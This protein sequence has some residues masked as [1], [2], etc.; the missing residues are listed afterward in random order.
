MPLQADRDQP[1][2]EGAARKAHYGDGEQPWDTIKN[3]GWAPEF[4]AGNVVKYLRRTKDPE[5]SLQSA[6]WYYARLKELIGRGS[7][8]HEEGVRASYVYKALMKE[9][10]DEEVRRVTD[11]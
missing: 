11:R 10:T 1:G 5:H 4:A 9:L 3:A 7:R 8:S 2:A 6:R